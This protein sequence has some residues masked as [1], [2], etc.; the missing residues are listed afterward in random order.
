VKNAVKLYA[1][2]AMILLGA[3][4]VM[5]GCKS[6]PELTQAQAQ[7]LIQAKYDQAPAEPVTITVGDRGMQ[8]G[9]IAKYWGE[10]KLYPNHYW[11]DFAFTPD[12][13]KLVK[14]KDGGDIIQWRPENATDKNFT[15][16][17]QTLAAVH[18]RAHDIGE[19]QRS[20]EKRTASFSEAINLDSLPAPLQDIAHNPG[21]KL[22]TKRTATFV[23]NGDA[24]TL[25]SIQ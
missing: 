18:L 2:G 25:Q 4:A 23:L 12:G 10:T 8:Q 3:M 13:K 16:V 5:S 6:A 14:L 15:I 20:G 9:V 1:F 22:S 21:N 17:I 24:W 11:G 19:I 7:A